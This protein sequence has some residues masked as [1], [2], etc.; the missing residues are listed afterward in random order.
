METQ[1][2]VYKHYGV[3]LSLKEERNSDICYYMC[4]VEDIVLRETN[5]TQ[6]V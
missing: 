6:T 5:Q 4:E 3:L 1:T 2:V